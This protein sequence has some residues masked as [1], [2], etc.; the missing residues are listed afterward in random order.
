MRWHF[1]IA[2]A[3]QGSRRLIAKEVEAKTVLHVLIRRRDKEF[4]FSKVQI[5]LDELKVVKAIKE[6]EDWMIKNVVQDTF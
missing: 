4:E 1:V 5:L 2:G 6:D 3:Y